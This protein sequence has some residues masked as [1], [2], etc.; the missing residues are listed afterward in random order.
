[1]PPFVNR[2]RGEVV[3]GFRLGHEVSEPEHLNRRPPFQ[4]RRRPPQP[5][6]A[7]RELNRPLLR[8]Q[9]DGRLRNCIHF[10]QQPASRLGI[11]RPPPIKNRRPS[12]PGPLLFPELIPLL[13][14]PRLNFVNPPATDRETPIPHGIFQID[15]EDNLK[16]RRSR[17]PLPRRRPSLRLLLTGP[18]KKQKPGKNNS[19]RDNGK[20]FHGR[21]LDQTRRV[22]RDAPLKARTLIG[23]CVATHPTATVL[24]RGCCLSWSSNRRP[25]LYGTI[26]RCGGWLGWGCL[27]PG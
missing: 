21:L 2:D 12:R 23:R 17:R 1:M 5:N 19:S 14:A 10:D 26:R 4:K 18:P 20:R 24:P 25:R 13:K 8:L 7:W 15:P 11:S 9:F 22:R 6:L 16:P 3:V 27:Q